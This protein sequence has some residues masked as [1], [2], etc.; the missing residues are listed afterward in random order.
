[1]IRSTITFHSGAISVTEHTSREQALGYV[2][3]ERV[4]L[5]YAIRSAVVR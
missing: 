5:G 3:A 2:A 4:A 1:M